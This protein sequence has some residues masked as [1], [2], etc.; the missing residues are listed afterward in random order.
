MVGFYLFRGKNVIPSD[1]HLE[2]ALKRDKKSSF[3]LKVFIPSEGRCK[4]EK[5]NNFPLKVKTFG[6][7]DSIPSDVLPSEV[8]KNPPLKVFIPSDNLP[9]ERF[10]PITFRGKFLILSD[11]HLPSEGMKSFPLEGTWKV[12]VHFSKKNSRWRELSFSKFE[13]IYLVGF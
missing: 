11:I 1:V 10:C 6:G 9:S 12:P 4:S 2:S 3:P 13:D 7:K 8:K 5:K